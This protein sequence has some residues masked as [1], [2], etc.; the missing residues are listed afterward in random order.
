MRHNTWIKIECTH[1]VMR[2]LSRKVWHAY[3][4]VCRVWEEDVFITSLDGD[5]HMQISYHYNGNAFDVR[6]PAINRRIK[7]EQL[8]KTLGT[9]YDV[10]E[11]DNYIHI[12]YDPD[13]IQQGL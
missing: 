3:Q 1:G 4:T 12:E 5:V 13:F 8:I 10:V 7:I 11:N 6:P 2:N 9:D